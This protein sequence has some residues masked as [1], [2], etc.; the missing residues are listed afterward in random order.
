MIRKL[1]HPFVLSVAGLACLAAAAFTLAV[2]A[3]LAAT[4]AAL[5]LLEWRIDR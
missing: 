5:L 3:G 4:G 1:A 2:P